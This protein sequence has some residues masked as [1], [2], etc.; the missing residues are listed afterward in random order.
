MLA[1]DVMVAPVITV[2]PYSSIKTVAD[3]FWKRHISG[4]PVVD[5]NGK[6]VGMISEGDLVYRS[7][8]K[9]DRPHPYWFLQ[10]AGKENLAKEYAKSHAKHVSD[11]MTHNVVTAAPDT[12][13]GDIAALMERNFIKRVPIVANDQL[14]GI[15]TRANLV[16]ALASA[17]R[18]LDIP[19]SD[20]TIRA[21]LL[22]ELNKQPWADASRLNLI[23][24]DGVVEIW[25]TVSSDAERQA[26]RVAAESMLGVSAVNNH[27]RVR[28]AEPPVMIVAPDIAVR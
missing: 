4:A 3:L 1:R 10:V 22:L 15:L 6:I 17:P 26:V 19:P 28:P 11:V 2:K 16:Q 21:K 20:S 5:D 7:E 13:L 23:V 8:L 9:T 27:L 24:H 18:G 25:G 14:V 12:P